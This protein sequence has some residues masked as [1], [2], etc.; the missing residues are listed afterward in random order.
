MELN[1]ENFNIRQTN[2]KVFGNINLPE[3]MERYVVKAQGIIG[4]EIFADDKIK[5]T[6]LEGGQI[7]EVS[8]FDNL[9]KNNQS[10]ILIEYRYQHLFW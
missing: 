3:N 4:V 2:P 1:L 7:C 5:I 9:G 10:I 8:V 6:N